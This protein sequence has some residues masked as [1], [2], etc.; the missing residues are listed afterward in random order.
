VQGIPDDVIV[1]IPVIASARGV[2]GIKMNPLPRRVMDNVINPRIR[3]M[4]NLHEAYRNGDRS[5][6]VLELMNDH[7]IQEHETFYKKYF[8]VKQT[9]KRGIQVEVKQ[10]DVNKAKRY[11]GYF[12]L[13]SNERMDSIQRLSFTAIKM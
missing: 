4:D 5:L 2:Q 7:R 3:T 8:E 13:L 10:D 12:A 11:Y 1:E 9:P 6:L